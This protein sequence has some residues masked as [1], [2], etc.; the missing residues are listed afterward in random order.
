MGGDD[1]VAGARGLTAIRLSD[2]DQVEIEASSDA[3]IIRAANP[4][5][6]VEAMFAGRSPAIGVKPMPLPMIGDPM[7]AG[8]IYPSDNAG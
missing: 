6:T 3:I 1:G 4:K 7:S 2:G 8:K 5:F